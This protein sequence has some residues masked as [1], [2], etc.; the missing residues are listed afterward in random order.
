MKDTEHIDLLLKQALFSNIGPS[1]E[2]NQKIINKVNNHTLKVTYKKR[3]A[4][5]FIVAVIFLIMTATAF[6]VWRLLTPEEVAEH[7]DDVPLAIAFEGEDAIKINKSVSSGGYHFTLLGIVSGEGLNG[8]KSSVHDIYPDRTY[9]VI[10]IEKEDGS[11]IPGFGDKDSESKFFISPLIKGQKPWLVNI[12][13]M[14]GGYRECV[15][16]GVMYR[17]IE[18]DGIEMF[19]DRGLYLCINSGTFY[20]ID[21]F[22]YDERSGEITPNPDYKG[23]NIIFDLPL[24]INKADHKKADEYLKELLE[25]EDDTAGVDH[26]EPI[27]DIEKEFEN[28]AVIPESIK[29]VTF[30]EKG[31]AYYEYGGSKVGLSIEHF[32]KEGETGVWKNTAVF[33]S[34]EERILVQIMKDENGVITG[35]AIKLK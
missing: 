28:G 25:P 33:G 27:I 29:E 30:D 32:F 15:I 20:D 18:C 3:L 6:A 31:M 16:D 12:A 7:F 17:L 24:D 2:L 26:E 5:T 14:N 9:A 1:N 10:S 13:S 34:D 22:I 21:A 35:T 11:M 23:I 19:A 4:F 8:I